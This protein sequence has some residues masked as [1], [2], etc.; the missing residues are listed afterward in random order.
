MIRSLFQ[1]IFEIFIY[2]KLC[3][4]SV[5]LVA[6]SLFTHCN[7]SWGIQLCSEH[8]HAL[9]HSLTHSTPHFY[10]LTN[11]SC[12]YHHRSCSIYHIIISFNSPISSL[13]SV[14]LL[15]DI[16]ITSPP[17]HTNISLL[18]IPNHNPTPIFITFI[19]LVNVFYA[20]RS[21]QV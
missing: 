1:I 10:I 5:L 7:R 12:E 15:M 17:L 16:H 4:T 19:N 9:T 18:V 2:I 20:I 6:R 21:D 8:N 13:P 3:R 11:R 14:S